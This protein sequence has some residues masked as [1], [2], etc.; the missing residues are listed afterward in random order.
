MDESLEDIISVTEEHSNAI[1][2]FEFTVAG[3]LL[4]IVCIFGILGN[5]FSLIVLS[6]EKTK[7]S[8][9]CYLQH[10]AVYDLL[11]LIC[12]IFLNVM[13]VFSDHQRNDTILRKLK[14]ICLSPFPFIL[15]TAY[16]VR[17]G[18]IWATVG[19]SFER[20]VVICHPLK[21]VTFCTFRKTILFNLLIASFVLFFS[22]PRFFENV[23]V[24]QFDNSSNETLTILRKTPF[25]ESYLF[26]RVYDG[27]NI[28]VNNV[29]PFLF[30]FFFN[31]CIYRAL[32]QARNARQNMTEKQKSDAKVTRILFCVVAIFFIC[33]A[34]SCLFVIS[35]M[36]GL[37]GQTFDEYLINVLYLVEGINSSVNFIIYCAVGKNFRETASRLFC[38][39]ALRT[40]TSSNLK[41]VVTLDTMS[42]E[43]TDS[44]SPIYEE[45]K[46]NE[47]RL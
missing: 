30:L 4:S 23:T 27:L 13:H 29:L 46:L 45:K 16:T 28:V 44:L 43:A 26:L 37:G 7:S 18:S 12:K 9:T 8:I 25:G 42:T 3:V 39:R 21:A 20:Y 41:R 5:T 15:A 1:L 10:L 6:R 11:Y 40:R 2:Y 36:T 24:K 47:E 19:L 34:P 22:L 33:Y 38:I 14:T 32:K 35:T 31:I 17:T